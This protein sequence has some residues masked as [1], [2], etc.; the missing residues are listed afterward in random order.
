MAQIKNTSTSGVVERT[1]NYS[2]RMF[3][4]VKY[5]T[6]EL[7]VQAGAKEYALKELKLSL[8]LVQA[9]APSVDD[10]AVLQALYTIKKN[11]ITNSMERIETRDNAFDE[12]VL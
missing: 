8:E 5:K 11:N 10:K 9:V 1:T 3:A 4:G 2:E 12:L 7:A 6:V